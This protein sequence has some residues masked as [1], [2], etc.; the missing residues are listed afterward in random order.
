[1]AVSVEADETGIRSA[2]IVASAATEKAVR[3]RAAEQCL[4]GAAPDEKKLRR[5]GEVAA[6]EVECIS[7]VRGSA[8][9]KR[10]L[11]RGHVQRAL[12]A[13]LGR[14]ETTH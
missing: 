8:A 1:V 7:D 11:I 4:S 10:E 5:A 13:G 12:Q 9:Y 2:R 3:L 14:P 6:D